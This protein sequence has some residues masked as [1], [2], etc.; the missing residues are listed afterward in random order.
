MRFRSSSGVIGVMTSSASQIFANATS[1]LVLATLHPLEEQ[2]VAQLGKKIM[3][4]EEA[5]TIEVQNQ[6]WTVND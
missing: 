4:V 5:M 3:A 6:F 1:K 2:N